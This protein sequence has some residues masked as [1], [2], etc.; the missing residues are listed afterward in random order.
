M[1][2]LLILILVLAHSAQGNEPKPSTA[3]KLDP[4]AMLGLDRQLEK[5]RK[6]PPKVDGVVT[7]AMKPLVPAPNTELSKLSL[8]EE[9][10]PLAKPLAK[11]QTPNVKG[12]A[13]D[14]HLPETPGV[15]LMSPEPVPNQDIH[16]GQS[17]ELMPSPQPRRY[18]ASSTAEEDIP[19]IAPGGEVAVILAHQRFL[20]GRIHIPA[21]VET[22]LIFTTINQQPAA[23]IIERLNVQRWIN[24]AAAATTNSNI[25]WEINREVSSK[26]V[27]EI[28]LKADK[29]I[30]SFHDAL[31]GARGEIV[32]D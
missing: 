7:P 24:Q 9:P 25:P 31:T 11:T 1:R 15:P 29:G 30:Y 20:P 26:H 3:P 10:T 28:L 27:T 4:S 14:T 23:L 2:Y 22:R 8:P 21:G 5:D 6:A 13:T 16:A 17:P 32:V 12:D 19:S 18:V